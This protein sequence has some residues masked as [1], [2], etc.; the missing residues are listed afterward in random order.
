MVL[1]G[2]TG[3]GRGRILWEWARV[4][5]EEGNPQVGF[6]G[7]NQRSSRGENKCHL[8]IWAL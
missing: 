8:G 7:V 4:R 1:G 5:G 2:R 3:R 6:M